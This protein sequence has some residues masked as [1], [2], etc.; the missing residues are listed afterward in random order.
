MQPKPFGCARDAPKTHGED[1]SKRAGIDA[2]PNALPSSRPCDAGRAALAASAR[3][4]SPLA[5]LGCAKASSSRPSPE[6]SRPTRAPGST[7]ARLMLDRHGASCSPAPPQVKPGAS[8]GHHH[9]DAV[10]AQL[11]PG[12]IRSGHSSPASSALLPTALAVLPCVCSPLRRLP[13]AHHRRRGGA[14]VLR[15]TTARWL[16]RRGR[17]SMEIPIR[18]SPIAT[19][20]STTCSSSRPRPHRE[21]S[22]GSSANEALPSKPPRWSSTPSTSP[23]PWGPSHGSPTSAPETST[24]AGSRKCSNAP[25]AASP[26]SRRMW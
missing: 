15:R 10:T 18:S 7:L 24:S 3:P 11:A 21:R 19:R 13:A 12:P 9:H 17:L 25:P 20:C 8:R 14:A 6:A 26:R 22:P 2:E 4:R 1:G 16:L 23:R 5:P